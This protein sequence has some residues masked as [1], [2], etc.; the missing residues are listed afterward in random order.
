MFWL[1]LFP[2]SITVQ[3]STVPNTSRDANW[4]DES[5]EELSRRMLHTT[6]WCVVILF[7]V[8]S[9]SSLADFGKNMSEH[10]ADGS[11]AARCRKSMTVM[12]PQREPVITL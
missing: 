5:V 12:V 8:V 3:M 10:R 1:S 11:E 2:V 6:S 7:I 9:F 4:Y